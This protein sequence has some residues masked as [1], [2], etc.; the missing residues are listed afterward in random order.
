MIT[1]KRPLLFKNSNL[2]FKKRTPEN[3]LVEMF[4]KSESRNE[5]DVTFYLKKWG[6]SVMSILIFPPS[7]GW[8]L[9]VV[10]SLMITSFV[11]VFWREAITNPFVS[12]FPWL[13]ET[14]VVAA[15]KSIFFMALPGQF[16]LGLVVIIKAHAWLG[17]PVMV[18]IAIVIGYFRA[19]K[20]YLKS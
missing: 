4:L 20:V 11:G 2:L 8:L 1:R 15:R 5:E 17:A 16:M 18:P 19:H 6:I 14:K 7:Y 12:L 3:G 9:W 10:F 13:A